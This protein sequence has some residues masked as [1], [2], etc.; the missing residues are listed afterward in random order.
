[1]RR[2]K[3][4]IAS[5]SLARIHKFASCMDKNPGKLRRKVLLV[6]TLNDAQ[7]LDAKYCGA[8]MHEMVRLDTLSASS[9][10][11]LPSAVLYPSSC[12]YMHAMKDLKVSREQ[13]LIRIRPERA[14]VKL[15]LSS[16]FLKTTLRFG[17]RVRSVL[18]SEPKE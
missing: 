16:I 15:S 5:Q 9:H 1:V 7:V 12:P 18:T 14:S 6:E 2:R 3:Q 13:S 17:S 10:M 4:A 11:S 8:S